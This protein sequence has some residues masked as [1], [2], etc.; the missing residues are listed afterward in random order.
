M[1]VCNC[2]ILYQSI[3]FRCVCIYAFTHF[4]FSR[5]ALFVSKQQQGQ[6]TL[7]GNDFSFFRF[8]AFLYLVFVRA[9]YSLFRFFVTFFS[10]TFFLFFV[11]I[12]F[13]CNMIN[14]VRLLCT[15]K[16]MLYTIFEFHMIK[17]EIQVNNLQ[18]CIPVYTTFK[19]D[20]N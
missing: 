3:V 7:F 19:L 1:F 18:V 13:F 12:L 6:I 17:T 20:G 2:C 9:M 4:L 14:G 15:K 8:P 10:S 16:N 5:S 11:S